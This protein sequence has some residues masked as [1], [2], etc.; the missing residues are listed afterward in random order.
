M[1]CLPLFFPHQDKQGRDVK[2]SLTISFLEA[3]QGC[4]KDVSFQFLHQ[5][6]GSRDTKRQTKKVNVDLPKGVE[7]G[8]T[9]KMTGQGVEAAVGHAVGEIFIHTCMLYFN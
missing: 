9:M 5:K 6:P 8:M 7:S 4:N 2:V 1:Y 3:V